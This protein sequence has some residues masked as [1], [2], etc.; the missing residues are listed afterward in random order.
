MKVIWLLKDFKELLPGELYDIM[1]LRQQVFIVEQNCHYLDAD[2]KDVK[3]YHLTGRN[4]KNE[5]AAYA[6]IVFPGVSYTEVSIGRVIT[7]HEYR[8]T[9]LGILLM[10]E[11]LKQIEH[12][13]GKVPV[14]IGAQVYL[15]DFYKKFGFETEG[16][17]YFEDGIKHVIMLRK[18]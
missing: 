15:V 16:D 2:G 13:Y 10:E 9:G 17:I 4:E 12:I 5:L 18:V 8:R 6:R 1:Q 11:S 3:S 7:A 14:R